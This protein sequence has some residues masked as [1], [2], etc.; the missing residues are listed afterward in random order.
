MVWPAIVAGG[1]VGAG[2]AYAGYMGYKG[3]KQ[4]NVSTGD[5]THRLMEY[6]DRTRKDQQVTNVNNMAR[7]MDYNVRE[8]KES[9]RYGDLVRKDVQDYG[10]RMSSTQVQRR[11]ADLKAAGINPILAMG[12]Q[13]AGIPGGGGANVN[14]ASVAQPPQA[15]GL[16]GARHEVREQKLAGI[17]AARELASVAANIMLTKEKTKTEKRIQ[18]GIK[19]SNVVKETNAYLYGNILNLMKSGSHSANNLKNMF[20]NVGGT[21]QSKRWNFRAEQKNRQNLKRINRRK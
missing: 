8:R 1:L 12:A 16:P 5:I 11:Y 21:I 18:T 9:Q 17:T 14:A 7:V 6:Q 15:A 19:H 13:G 4:A 2:T 10:E 3:A 20:K